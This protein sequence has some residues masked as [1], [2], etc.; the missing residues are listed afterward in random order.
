M[1]IS[2]EMHL[3]ASSQI[4]RSMESL[5]AKIEELEEWRNS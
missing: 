1:L 3:E 4:H 2:L 5:Q